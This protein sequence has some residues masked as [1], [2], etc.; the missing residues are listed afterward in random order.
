MRKENKKDLARGKINGKERK[1]SD[2][3]VKGK[4][5][6]NEWKEKATRKSE[7][8]MEGEW[9]RERKYEGERV[10]APSRLSNVYLARAH[11]FRKKGHHKYN[12]PEF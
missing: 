10:K 5:S 3:R 8:K 1:E 12:R 11:R 6:E 4:D 7:G 9:E 2:I